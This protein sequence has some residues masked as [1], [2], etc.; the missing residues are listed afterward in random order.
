VWS[1]P[2]HLRTLIENKTRLWTHD[3]KEFRD[4]PFE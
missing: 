3:G 2:V 4:S 1:R